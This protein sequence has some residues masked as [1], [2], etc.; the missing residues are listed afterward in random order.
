MDLLTAHITKAMDVDWDLQV[1]AQEQEL[2]NPG[3]DVV[4]AFLLLL[5]ASIEVLVVAL[6]HRH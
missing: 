6:F 1:M 4:Q 2:E 3:R 5:A